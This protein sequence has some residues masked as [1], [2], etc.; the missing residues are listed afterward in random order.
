MWYIPMPSMNSA[1]DTCTAN[2][3][4]SQLGILSRF[5]QMAFTVAM[6]VDMNSKS[7]IERKIVFIIVVVVKEL[8]EI[9][10]SIECMTILLN[11]IIYQG[12]DIRFCN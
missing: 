8:F 1:M 4:S 7:P 10:Q 11:D 3:K 12:L 2:K 6:T 5:S 9:F